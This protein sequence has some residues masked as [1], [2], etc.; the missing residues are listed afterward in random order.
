MILNI[1]NLG[2]GVVAASLLYVALKISIKIL[3]FILIIGL[4]LFILTVI[5]G[6]I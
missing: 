5:D 2:L 4:I 1:E 3:T 6:V